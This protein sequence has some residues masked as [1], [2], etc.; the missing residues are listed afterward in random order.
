MKVW[1]DDPL[2]LFD[3]KSVFKFWPNADQSL[4]ERINSGSRFIIY[5]SCL[6]YILRRDVRVIIVGLL[7]LSGLYIIYRRGSIENLTSTDVQTCTKQ[8]IDNPMANVMLT[9]YLI[10]PE[11]PPACDTVHDEYMQSMMG[12][13]NGRSRAPLPEQQKYAMSRQ[14]ITAPVSTIPNDQTSFAEFCYGNKGRTLCRD[15]TSVCDPNFR[16]V[17]LEA[18]GGLNMSGNIRG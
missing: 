14:F 6:V 11:R 12:I 13:G 10:N 2:I 16:G 4:E 9:D 3:K 18:Y 15:D 5:A 7:A 17:Q 8:T 1:F